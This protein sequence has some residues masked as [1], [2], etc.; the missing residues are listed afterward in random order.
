ME[1]ELWLDQGNVEQARALKLGRTGKR[2]GW[3]EDGVTRQS[4]PT[5]PERG[6]VGVTFGVF[7]GSRPE[8]QSVSGRVV[9]C[10][11]RGMGGSTQKVRTSVEYHETTHFKKFG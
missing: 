4:M 2:G 6:S 11:L 7:Q 10:G 3:W 8:E 1:E 5:C 9:G